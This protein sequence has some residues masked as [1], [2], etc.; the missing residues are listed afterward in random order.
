MRSAPAIPASLR[1]ELLTMRI[2][3]KLAPLIGLEMIVC[4]PICGTYVVLLDLR[5]SPRARCAALEQA[6]RL[7]RAGDVAESVQVAR[8]ELPTPFSEAMSVRPRSA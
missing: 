3:W 4:A 8:I 2:E 6:L 7:V 1:W 5:L